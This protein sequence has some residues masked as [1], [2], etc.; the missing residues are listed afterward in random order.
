MEGVVLSFKMEGFLLRVAKDDTHPLA[1]LWEGG[2]GKA[3]LNAVKSVQFNLCIS[4]NCLV[5][6]R[7]R[8]SD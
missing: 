4:R 2:C 5:H 1:A 3:R 8:S 7:S 6:V